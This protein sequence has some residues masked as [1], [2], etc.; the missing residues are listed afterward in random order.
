MKARAPNISVPAIGEI[1]RTARQQK[2]LSLRELAEKAFVSAS[3]L[4]QIETGKVYP[5]VRSIYSIAAALELPVEYFFPESNPKGNSRPEEPLFAIGDFASSDQPELN[6]TQ[7]ADISPVEF[8]SQPLP[9][10]VVRARKRATIE[11][12]GGVT[13]SRLTAIAEAGAEFLEI[14]YAA[15]VSSGSSMSHH[16]G[17]EFGVVLEGELVVELAFEAYS[18]GPGDSIIFDASTPHRI[19]NRAAQPARALWVVFDPPSQTTPPAH[20]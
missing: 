1:F 13:W 14:T 6:T 5:S 9:G 2:K 15:G 19:I 17:R 11:L 4:S 16:R 3:M 8:I 10:P 7:S 18:L 12:S 20:H